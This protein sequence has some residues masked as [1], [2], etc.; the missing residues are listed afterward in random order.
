ME[1]WCKDFFFFFHIIPIWLWPEFCYIVG[2]HCWLL[3]LMDQLAIK[4]TCAFCMGWREGLSIHIFL[5]EPPFQMST[6]R[7]MGESNLQPPNSNLPITHN[8]SRVCK[9]NVSLIM[10]VIHRSS[11]FRV[12]LPCFLEPAEPLTRYQ[13]HLWLRLGPPM[14]Y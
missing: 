7:V 11:A 8:G 3:L 2:H 5:C 1:G 14:G 9:Y 12:L 4:Y 13:S 6:M 10:S